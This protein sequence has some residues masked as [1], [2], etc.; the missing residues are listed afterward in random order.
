VIEK[1]VFSP[2][3]DEVV[4]QGTLIPREETKPKGSFSITVVKEKE[5]SKYVIDACSGKP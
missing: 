2:T 4:L 5:K 3:K 1:V